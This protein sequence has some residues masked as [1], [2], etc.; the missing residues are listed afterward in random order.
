MWDCMSSSASSE[1]ARNPP[2]VLVLHPALAPYRV[3][4]FNAMA[5]VSNL[6][7]VLIKKNVGNQSF[8]QEALV[9]ALNVSP[10]YL[11]KNYKILGK[12]MALL[13]YREV[14]A[15]SPDIVITSEFSPTTALMLFY[16]LMS[17]RRFAHVVWTDDN[18]ASIAGDRL[19][20]RL[21]RKLLL[22]HVDGWIFVS[23]D[24]RDLYEQ[25]FGA[26]GQMAVVPIIR[27]ETVFTK[28]LAST[29]DLAEEYIASHDLEGKRV[30]LFIGRMAEEK[31]LDV[32]L[33]AFA[34]LRMRMDDVV[35][36]LVGSGEDGP[37]LSKLAAELGIIEHAKFVGRYEGDALLA[38]YRVGQVFA[39]SSRFERFGA[40]IN[41]ALLAGLPVVVSDRAGAKSLVTEGVNGSVVPAEDA[42]GFAKAIE[43]WIKKVPPLTSGR[44]LSASRMPI[45]FKQAAASINTLFQALAARGAGRR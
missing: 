40:V 2:N 20:R 39:I 5:E 6:N 9:R 17:R 27:D 13:T 1:P 23:E 8:D 22:P 4:T 44:A 11:D 41:E 32:L 3:D 34:E 7:L 30:V 35:L 24:A 15:A 26:R 16:R 14:M 38:W 45:T 43:G 31:G 28:S 25:R 36:V 37:A 10:R 42:S 29:A 19:I 12:R 33:R 18:G 21:G